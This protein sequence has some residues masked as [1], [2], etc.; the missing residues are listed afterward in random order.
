MLPELSIVIINY[1]TFS[2]SSACIRSII[3]YELNCNYE[4]ILVDNASSECLPDEFQNEFPSIKIVKSDTNLGFAK[5]NNLG[6]SYAQ[7]KYILLLNS[8]VV[9]REPVLAKS[10]ERL[11]QESQLGFLTCKL[12]NLDG[13]IQRQCHRFPSIRLILIEKL[14][15]HKLWSKNKRSKILLNGY[16]DHLS[17]RYVDRVW[18][19]F[20]M[21]NKELLKE[22]PSGILTE[23][24]FMYGEDT[25]WC[26]IVKKIAKK[27]ILYF[28]DISVYHLVGGSKFNNRNEIIS[29]NRK[30]FLAKYYGRLKSRT[31]LLLGKI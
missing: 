2:L 22:F 24:F 4:I 26:Y 13:S 30:I 21:F 20:L 14:R 17:E 25:E 15:L 8:D 27:R 5:G 10:L 23:T 7:G 18:G 6:I 19:T 11:K 16:F 29:Q 9:L 28:P 12:L 31:I 1:N 3:E